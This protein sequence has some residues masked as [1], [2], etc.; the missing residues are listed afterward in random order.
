[1]PEQSD[2]RVELSKA[3]IGTSINILLPG[4]GSLAVAGI[5][6]LT[7]KSLNQ[8]LAEALS[9]AIEAVA[10]STD[11]RWYRPAKKIRE[12]RGK[13]RA[14]RTLAK[15]VTFA[16]LAQTARRQ[17]D[18]D[19]GKTQRGE[20]EVQH[21]DGLQDS[22]ELRGPNLLALARSQIALAIGPAR[23]SANWQASF[24]RLL[25]EIA[26]RALKD[27][28]AAS[29][30]NVIQPG[31]NVR[32]T[33][34]ELAGWSEAVTLAFSAELGQTDPLRGYLGQLEAYDRRSSHE[35]LLWQ[36]DHQRRALHLIA[37][38]LLTL[39]AAYSVHLAF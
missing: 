2:L 28:T 12:M 6:R 10:G 34:A 32:P 37:A 29:L 11:V 24:A 1:V 13:R 14:R 27:P 5:G 4:V 26:A 33:A 22:D 38:A 23:G 17:F 8:A 30:L 7:A 19:D 9:R 36:I 16:E 31:T 21:L 35:A 39:A 3:V 20:V 18:T 15:N 25:E